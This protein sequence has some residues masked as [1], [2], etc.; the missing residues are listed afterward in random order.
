MGGISVD[1]GNKSCVTH[2]QL[3]LRRGAGGGQQSGGL[4]AESRGKKRVEKTREA[5][6]CFFLPTSELIQAA[7]RPASH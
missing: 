2:G 6:D 1:C 3:Y 5:A 7:R 4:S